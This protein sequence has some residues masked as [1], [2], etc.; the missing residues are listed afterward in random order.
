MPSS[1]KITFPR[2]ERLIIGEFWAA[3]SRDASSSVRKSFILPY[4]WIR[5]R[6]S[7]ARMSSRLRYP[8]YP[9]IRSWIFLISPR[10]ASTRSRMSGM[11]VPPDVLLRTH[12]FASRS[13]STFSWYSHGVLEPSSPQ[14]DRRPLAVDHLTRVPVDE[15][16][17]LLRP[18]VAVPHEP[19]G[20]VQELPGG[21]LE[22]RHE[23]L[24]GV[25][26]L[27][28]LLLRVLL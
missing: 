24:Q 13:I 17:H 8:A 10:S 12:F 11:C 22:V 4:I 1:S 28:R 3:A 23:G 26:A 18:L 25:Y 21:L 20:R 19:H 9:G 16:E 7:A 14:G 6:L 27:L 5:S 15:D 2:F